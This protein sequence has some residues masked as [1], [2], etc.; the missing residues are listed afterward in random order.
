[1]T[2]ST[3]G[4]RRRG[5]YRSFTSPLSPRYGYV[6]RLST[7]WQL[8]PFVVGYGL[9]RLYRLSAP[10][11]NVIRT[12]KPEGTIRVTRDIYCAMI[13]SGYKRVSRRPVTRATGFAIVLFV[14][15][16]FTFDRE[17]EERRKAGTALDFHAIFASPDVARYLS[18]LIEYANHFN[19][20]KSI[21][22][23]LEDIFEAHYPAY[24]EL[25]MRCLERGRFDDNLALAEYDSGRAFMAMYE[26]IRMFNCHPYDRA[27]AEQFY[28][29][30]MSGKFLDDLADLAADYAS[31]VPN[32][33][34][35]LAASETGE[36]I[37]VEQ[38]LAEHATLDLYWWS[39]RCSRT[40]GK[41][42]ELTFSYYDLISDD[43]L[44]LP[45]NLLL[46]VLHGKRFWAKS[47]GPS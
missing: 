25:L 44:R 47:V 19:A 6:H 33:V 26:I 37:I 45:V 43:R 10:Q 11:R 35:S 9:L 8:A 21:A 31:G 20:G 30:G 36:R 24:C 23:Y 17:F 39:Q 34:L 14:T 18:A 41:F 1:V 7:R 12:L 46:L 22:A 38:A 5:W 32:L 13:V 42:K 27:C 29:V 2:A 3:R 4:I 16:I 28:A 40:F 15:F